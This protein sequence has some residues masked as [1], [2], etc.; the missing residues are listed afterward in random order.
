MSV[1]PCPPCPALQNTLGALFGSGGSFSQK[2]VAA[3]LP[4][5]YR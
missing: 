1:L 4:M 3:S 2:L 5:M